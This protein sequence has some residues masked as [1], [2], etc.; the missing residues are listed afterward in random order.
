MEPIKNIGKIPLEN[1]QIFPT[2]PLPAQDT[3]YGSYEAVETA[4]QVDSTGLS[5]PVDRG[6]TRQ[7]SVIVDGHRGDTPPGYMR[8]RIMQ[9]VYMS[10]F[11]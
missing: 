3:P 2:Y 10:V 6:I 11:Q 8:V 7:E 1:F 4:G 5:G 9:K